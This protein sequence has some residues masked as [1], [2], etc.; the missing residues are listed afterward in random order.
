MNILQIALLSAALLCLWRSF[1]LHRVEGNGHVDTASYA[2]PEGN[3]HVGDTASYAA[4]EGNGN[5]Q[6][7][8]MTW[9]SSSQSGAPD[10]NSAGARRNQL[11]NARESAEHEDGS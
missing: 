10:A 3:G 7:E 6:C 1:R 9:R 11:F 5:V 8:W 4:P 2:A